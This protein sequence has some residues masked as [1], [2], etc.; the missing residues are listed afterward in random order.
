MIATVRG[1]LQARENDSIVVNVGGIGLRVRVSS[2]ALANVGAPGG[3]VELFTHLR[4]REDELTLYGFTSQDELRLFETLLTVS[5]IGP[6]MALGVLS[7][8]PSETL[9]LAIAQGNVDVL[10]GIPGIGRKTAQ[11]LVL[12]LKSKVDVSG[13]GEVGELTAADQDVINA[14]VNLGFSAADAARAAQSVPSG[15]KSVEERI[16][17]ALQNLGG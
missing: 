5:G 10:T 2:R 7:A 4:V 1:K 16:R 17:I 12:E 9:R 15:T 3:E 14:L 11:R 13:L 8:A 6:K